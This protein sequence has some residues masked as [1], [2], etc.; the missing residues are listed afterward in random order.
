MGGLVKGLL[1]LVLLGWIVAWVGGVIGA[2]AVKRRTVVRDDPA[3]DDVALVAIFGP[4]DFVST[5]RS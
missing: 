1:R 4:L 3:A 5:A 2:I